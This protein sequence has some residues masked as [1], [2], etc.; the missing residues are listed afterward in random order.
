MKQ[1]TAL[2]DSIIRGVVTSSSQIE[3]NAHYSILDDSFSS[4]CGAT[5][6]IDIRNHGR[7]GNTVRNCL[8]ELNRR[9]DLIAAS[10]FV[11]VELGGNDCD[12]HWNEIAAD[13]LRR[14]LPITPIEEFI[15]LY[16]R[17]I[18][19]IRN[20]GS[21]PIILSLPPII[22]DLYFNTFTRKMNISQK[23]N[24]MEWLGGSTEYI[25]RWHEMYN[26]QLF[27][28]ARRLST[29][30]IDITTPFL[31]ISDL[32]RYFCEDGIHPNENG[33]RLIAETICRVAGPVIV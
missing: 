4:R 10:E 24:V 19:G 5:L 13:P 29:P 33:H 27:K 8:R 25:S 30:I 17:L 28:M 32:G 20:L 22:S 3:A 14:H 23:C 1:I 9:K 12:Y 26:V 15:V 2:G 21:R 16:N 31:E 11:V 18:E 6:G 7:Y